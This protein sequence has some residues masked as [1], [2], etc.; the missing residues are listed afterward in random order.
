MRR[1]GYCLYS[2]S[3]NRY[4]RRALPAP[5]KLTIAA[6]TET[7]QAIWGDALYFRNAASP[8]HEALC[9]KLGFAKLLK[10]ACLYEVF[11]LNDCAAELIQARR[12]AFAGK[13]D[14]DHLLDLLTPMLNG[15][16]YSYSDYLD[17]FRKDVSRFF[18]AASGGKAHPRH[19]RPRTMSSVVRGLLRRA[20]AALAGGNG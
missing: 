10:L 6:Q 7:G 4:S 19:W 15:D 12:A 14:P 18:P 11:N 17:V 16:S 13:T 3:V 8:A 9:G 2:L 1:H 20:K 5:F